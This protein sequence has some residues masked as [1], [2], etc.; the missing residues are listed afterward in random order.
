MGDPHGAVEHAQNLGVEGTA[1][2][3]DGRED[4]GLGTIRAARGNTQLSNRRWAVVGGYRIII[5][6]NQRQ[7]ASEL[8]L[9][10]SIQGGPPCDLQAKRAPFWQMQVRL[11]GLPS[12]TNTGCCRQMSR[13]M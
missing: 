10:N 4:V 11:S 13:H 3:T 2:R 1:N 9:S 8:R 5:S 6:G 12:G 7:P